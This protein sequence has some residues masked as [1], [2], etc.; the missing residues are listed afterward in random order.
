MILWFCKLE[1]VLKLNDSCT[2][3]KDSGIQWLSISFPWTTHVLTL[4]LKEASKHRR[5]TCSHC[6]ILKVVNEE[7]EPLTSTWVSENAASKA[8]LSSNSLS[9]CSLVHA[10]LIVFRE[11]ILVFVLFCFLT[12]NYCYLT[13]KNIKNNMFWLLWLPLKKVSILI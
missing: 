5:D 3:C 7:N 12:E 2:Q 8:V 1:Q 6:S 4:G 13:N 11:E 9:E 10:I